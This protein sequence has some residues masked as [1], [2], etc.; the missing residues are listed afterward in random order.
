MY[1]PASFLSRFMSRTQTQALT[2]CQCLHLEYVSIETM[3]PEKLDKVLSKFYAEV[4]KK[5]G[6]DYEPESLKIMQSA[7]E[8]IKRRRTIQWTSCDGGSF[9]P[10]KKSSMPKQF[11]FLNEESEKDQT[12]LSQSHLKKSQPCG[13]K[14]SCVILMERSWP[15]S[16]SKIWRNN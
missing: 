10:N 15:M 6:D 5:D 8:R 14:V 3:A 1:F 2:W 12:K 4:K 11:S 9:T 13:K 16:T 7:I